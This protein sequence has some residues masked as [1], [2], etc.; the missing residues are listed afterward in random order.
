MS[1]TLNIV[2]LYWPAYAAVPDA[3]IN[4]L[5]ADAADEIGTSASQ[6]GVLYGRALAA[7]VAHALEIRARS[8]NAANG[9]DGSGATVVSSP[10]S[11]KTGDLAVGYGD[12]SGTIAKLPAAGLSD[13]IYATTPGGMEYLRLRGRLARILVVVA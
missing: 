8:A 11:L 13:A 5:V 2:R 4:A 6:W 7:L 12:L 10:T 3:T 9:A 1:G